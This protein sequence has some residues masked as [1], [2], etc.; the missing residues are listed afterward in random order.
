MIAVPTLKLH[1]GLQLLVIE[2]GERAIERAAEDQPPGC[3]QYTG[4]VRAIQLARDLHPAGRAIDSRNHASK[5]F[6]PTSGPTIPEGAAHTGFVNLEWR[7]T[8]DTGTVNQKFGTVLSGWVE[9]HSAARVGAYV[10][11]RRGTSANNRILLKLLRRIV[12]DGFAGLRI[13]AF[14]PIQILTYWA[15]LMKKPLVRSKP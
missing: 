1:D 9:V 10:E 7:A 14:G 5:P 12:F 11:F 15:A 4:I 2:G 13:D 3:C 6:G 8:V